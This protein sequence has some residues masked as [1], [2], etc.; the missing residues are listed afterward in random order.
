MGARRE[1][2]GGAPDSERSFGAQHPVVGFDYDAVDGPPPED[3]RS[4]AE[5]ADAL[6]ELLQWIVHNGNHTPHGVY[7]RVMVLLFLIAPHSIGITT[8]KHL[9][10]R[11]G[12]S[13][14]W[15]NEVVQDFVRRYNFTAIHLKL[16]NQPKPARGQKV[17]THR[18]SKG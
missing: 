13:R 8:Q 12:V 14:S 17:L 18:R 11:L 15:V 10:Q 2:A 16:A 5:F 4:V 6:T 7:V 9:A 3:M 1:H